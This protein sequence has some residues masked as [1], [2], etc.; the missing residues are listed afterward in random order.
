MTVQEGQSGV[1]AGPEQAACFTRTKRG[2]ETQNLEHIFFNIKQEKTFQENFLLFLSNLLNVR[3]LSMMKTTTYHWI[4]FLLPHI[5]FY[6]IFSFTIR[7]WAQHHAHILLWTKL[8]LECTRRISFW[9]HLQNSIY[10]LVYWNIKSIHSICQHESK[11]SDSRT[12]QTSWQIF[13]WF[14]SNCD[15]LFFAD[16]VLFHKSSLF[17]NSDKHSNE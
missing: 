2:K 1:R 8:F 14:Y 6:F 10:F 13:G 5:Y 12:Q 11:P 17:P 7:Y 9:T 15:L 4:V 16:H 3:I